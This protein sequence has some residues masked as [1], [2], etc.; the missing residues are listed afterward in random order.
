MRWEWEFFSFLGSSFRR[1]LVTW[2]ERACVLDTA[3]LVWCR[4]ERSRAERC[5]LT[6]FGHSWLICWLVGWLLAYHTIHCAAF[7][8]CFFASGFFCSE[9][10]KGG[11]GLD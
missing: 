7:S 4:A 6:I 2:M 10:A 8:F 1:Y 5:E 9:G 3:D 11:M